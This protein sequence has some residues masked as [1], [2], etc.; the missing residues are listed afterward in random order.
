MRL[1]RRKKIIACF[2]LAVFSFELLLPVTAHALTSGPAQPEMQKFEVAGVTDMVDLFSGDMKYNIALMSVD[3]HP[4]NLSYA[5]GTGIEDEASW[6]GTGWSLNPGVV[7]RSM[8]GLPDDFNGEKITKTYYR[9]PFK[10]VGGALSVRG[11]L[12]GWEKGKASIELGVYKDNYYGIGASVGAGVSFQLALTSQTALGAGLNLLSDV[13]GGVDISPSLSLSAQTEIGK[14]TG[15]GSLSGGFSYNTRAGLRSV[16]LGASFNTTRNGYSNPSNIELSYVKYFGQTYTPTFQADTR[17]TSYT[18]TFDLG[19][20]FTGVY[21]GV[22]GK[23]YT[24]KENA[25]VSENITSQAYGYLNYLNGRKDNKALIDFNR[26]KDGVFIKG[27]PSIGVP[28]STHDFFNVSAQTGSQQFRPFFGGNYIVFDRAFSNT[29]ESATLGATVGFGSVVQGGGSFAYQSGNANTNKWVNNNTYL[30]PGEADFNASP[31]DEGVYFKQVGEKNEVDNGYLAKIGL[32]KTAQVMISQTGGSAASS[33]Q[34]LKFRNSPVQ[35][36][37]TT[38]IKRSVREKRTFDFSYLNAGQAAKYGL[39]KELK[40]YVS[41]Y[42]TIAHTSTPRESIHHKKDQISE[43]TVTDNNGQ[44]MVYGIPVMNNLQRDITFAVKKNN[45]TYAQSRKTGIYEYNPLTDPKVKNGNGRD[46]LYSKEDVPGYATSYLLSGVLSPDYVDR[47]GDGISDDDLGSAVKFR[48]TKLNGLFKWRAPYGTNKANYNEGFMSDHLDDKASVV[49]GEKE[50]WYLHSIEGKTMVAIFYT[51]DREDGLGVMNEHGTKN[52]A[53]KLQ[54]LDSIRLFSRADWAKDSLNAIPIKSVHM[55]YDYSITPGV[56]NRVDSDIT[57]GKLTLRKMYFKFGKSWRGRSNPY[58]FEYDVALVNQGAF[59]SNPDPLESQDRYTERQTDRWGTYK[60]SFYNRIVAGAG[61]LNNSEFPYVP[62]E[63]GVGHSERALADRFAS[64]WLLTKIKT[65]GS[66]VITVQYESDD[67]AFVQDRRAMQMCF[68]TG[69]ENNNQATGLNTASRLV[70]QLPQPLQ[71]GTLSQMQADFKQKYLAMSPGKF[72]ENIFY[73]ILTNLNN[74]PG[75]EEYVHGYAEIDWSTTDFPSTGLVRLGLK[76]IKPEKSNKLYNPISMAA[77]QLLRT[78]LPQYA[79]DNYDNLEVGD[80]QAAIRSI[81]QALKNYI[82]ELSKPFEERADN[83]NFADFVNLKKSMVRLTVPP[84]A[85]NKIAKIGGG[86]RVKRIHISDE[87]SEMVSG[88]VSA[89]YGQEYDYSLKDKNG[90]VYASS[91]VASYEPQIGNEENPFHEPINFSE[92]VHW[93][94]DRYHFV[95]KPFCESYFPAASVGYSS[96]TVTSF[97]VSNAKETGHIVNEFYTAKDF[98]TIVDYLPL[99]YKQYENSLTVKLFSSKSIDRV[100]VSQGFK[101]ELND[102]HGKPRSTKVFNKAGDLVSSTAYYYNVKDEN[103]E[104]KEL[105]NEVDVLDKNGTYALKTV[106]TDVDFVTDVRESTN[107]KSGDNIGVSGG[108]TLI[109]PFPLFL[110]PP[111]PVPLVAVNYSHSKFISSYNSIAAVKVIQ[112][113]GVIKKIVT[114]QNGSTIEAENLLWDSETG[115]VLLTKTQNEYDKYTYAFTYPAH[116]APEFEGMGPAYRNLGAIFNNLATGSN[117]DLS[118][119]SAYLFPG[120]ELVAL[121]TTKKGWVLRSAGGVL[122]LVDEKGDFIDATGMWQIVRSG[123]RNLL[124]AQIGTVVTAKDPRMGGT[125]VLDVDKRILA[126]KAIEYKDEWGIPV[127][128]WPSTYE[129]NCGSARMMTASHET[130]GDDTV[131]SYK[132][133]KDGIERVVEKVPHGSPGALFHPGPGSSCTCTCLKALFDY[134]IA[135]GQLFITQAQNKTVGQL[136]L[137]ANAAGYSVGSCPILSLNMDNP[138]Y[139]LTTSPTSTIYTARIGDCT[140]SIRSNSANPVTFSSLVSQTC[141]GTGNVVNYSGSGTQNTSVSFPVGCARTYTFSPGAGGSSTQNPSTKIRAGSYYGTFVPNSQNFWTNTEFTIPGISTIP[142][143]ATIVSAQLFLFATPD[144]FNPPTYTNAHTTTSADAGGGGTNTAIGTFSHIQTPSGWNC[145]SSATGGQ[146]ATPAFTVTSAFQ[147]VVANFTSTVQ[148]M[149]NAQVNN[150]FTFWAP[151]T[152]NGGLPVRRYKSFGSNTY[153]D[154]NK[155]PRLD[156]TYT[157][158]GTVPNVATLSIDNCVSCPDPVN[159]SLNPYFSGVLGNWRPYSDYSYTVTREQIPGNASQPAGTDIRHSGYYKEYT[160]FWEWQSNTLVRTFSPTIS[161]PVTDPRSRWIWNSRV[162]YYDQKGNQVETV[163]PLNRYGSALYG[164]RESVTTAVSGNAR[165]NEIAFDGFEDYGFQLQTNVNEPCKIARHFDWGFVNAGTAWSNAAGSLVSDVSHTGK[166]SYRLNQSI[167]ITRNAGNASP[168]AQILNFD[169]NGRTILLANELAK[170]FAP[171]AGKKYILSFWVKDN[172]AAQQFA[173]I[174][175]L[176]V[177]IY[178]DPDGTPDYTWNTAT[179]VPVVEGWKRLE[180]TFI[181]G[182]AFRLQISPGTQLWIDDF[183]ILPGEG[184]MSSYVFDSRSMRMMAQLDENNFA[185]LY[186]YDS[187]GT[188]VR[189]KKETER[190]LVT[191]KESRQSL[192]QRN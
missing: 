70:I 88:G 24:Y 187:E 158:S 125:I 132:R 82:G 189:I 93:A 42:S 150:G 8:R 121:T 145:N 41:P 181:A 176:N 3:E 184:R 62:Q 13:R 52:T 56:P 25:L 110:I 147:D 28:V 151:Y 163:D 30:V 175:N 166:Y 165:R 183:R 83:R 11:T 173:T 32:D 61:V 115:E 60:Q 16:S 1:E 133:T 68:V 65:P 29:S 72:H 31:V 69:V 92:K 154:V 84:N 36:L 6:V 2:F 146:W 102:M 122:R 38:P 160:P 138:F 142:A 190:G 177:N 192:R 53:Y 178:T 108:V 89:S 35:Q 152:G 155:R 75:K 67:Y 156:V 95:E 143:G 153:P 180:M 191:I 105:L 80:G 126:S 22:G 161:L 112:R 78:D 157:Y 14:E 17:S 104:T 39:D 117:G 55:E 140:V 21:G 128:P 113:F 106:G 33:Q 164:Y 169:G 134:L 124:A 170:G 59:P 19:G 127:A 26:E 148:N 118:S 171:I 172:D 34:A 54:K 49:Y 15:S 23:G 57:K 98:P 141:S 90:V 5:G 63:D 186:E 45:A 114:T 58:E 120:D 182:S 137:A 129:D 101:I 51:S 116:M 64:K 79:Y 86:S 179:T 168:P 81:V 47:T 40:S 76:K 174:Q 109:P 27:T 123:R 139:A 87:W 94:N 48:Y 130:K 144:G 43:I 100:G 167:T 10:K 97:G 188:P 107:N 9:K 18:F 20:L 91:G 46:E 44:R 7:N 96:V 71:S 85:A 73:K 119:Y 50:T 162:I 135:T 4:V 74:S 149:V 66:G 103:A 159:R 99:D 37:G 12:F 185:T 77:W 111:F 131:I 136:V